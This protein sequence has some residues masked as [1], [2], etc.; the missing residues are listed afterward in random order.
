MPSIA[1]SP[2]KPIQILFS[3]RPDAGSLFFER[4]LN[5][6]LFLLSQRSQHSVTFPLRATSSKSQSHV[7]VGGHIFLDLLFRLGI[8]NYL[9]NLNGDGLTCTKE[10][11]NLLS[12]ILFTAIPV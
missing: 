11:P 10:K 1:C 8:L 6:L 2:I 12:S 9:F 5:P 4:L 3:N 7:E